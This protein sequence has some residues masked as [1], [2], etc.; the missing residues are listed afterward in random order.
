MTKHTERYARRRLAS[1]ADAS[2]RLRTHLRKLLLEKFEQ[3]ELLAADAFAP[4]ALSEVPSVA[5]GDSAEATPHAE[6]LHAPA[7]FQAALPSTHL[8]KLGDFLSG[9][10]PSSPLEI[11]DQFLMERATEL[12]LSDLDLSDY[13]VTDNYQSTH[14]GV[15]HIYLQ[16]RYNGLPIA[17]ANANINVTEDGRIINVGSSFTPLPDEV[18]NRT[19]TRGIAAE[20]S[21]S[22]AESNARKL[23]DLSWSALAPTQLDAQAALE[24]LSVEL[25]W[26]IGESVE[27]IAEELAPANRGQRQTL[28]APDVSLDEIPAELQYVAVP[29]GLE[30]SWRLVVRRPDGMNWYDAHVSAETGELLHLSDWVSE[31]SY[32]VYALPTES[33]SHGGRTLEVDPQD[34][35]ASPFGWHDTNGV[36]GAEFNTTQGN[37]VWAY[38]D[39]DGDNLPDAGS[40]PDGGAALVFNPPLNFAGEPLTYRDASVTNLFYLSN[41]LHD[42]H[43]RYGFDESAG[44]FQENNY[45]NGGV[46]GDYVLAEAQDQADGGPSGPQRNNANFATPPDGINGRMQMFLFDLTTPERDAALDAG[47]VIHEYAHGVSTRLTGGPSNSGSLGTWQ[48]AGMGEGWSDWYA[49]ML[50]QRAGD[51]ANLARGAGTY[52][53]GQPPTGLGGRNLP[54]TYDMSVNN[55]TYASIVDELS[56]HN[57][58]EVWASVLWDLNWAMIDGSS[59]NPAYTTPGLGFDA[60]FYDG[61]G[62]NNLALQLV[63]DGMKLQP[64]SPSFLD[65][66][67]AILAADQVLTGGANQLTIWAVFARRG[68][69]YSADDGGSSNSTFVTEAFDMPSTSDGEITFA[70]VELSEGSL[71][72]VTLRD[73]DLTSAQTIQISSSGGD[74]ETIVLDSVGVF[75]VYLGQI[76][77]G[78]G[79][80]AAD[81]VLQVSAGDTISI[82]YIDADDGLGGTDVPNTATSTVLTRF[83]V[84]MEQ[85]SPA[86]ALL[87]ASRNLAITRSSADVEPFTFFAEAGELIS[88]TAQPAE[89]AI[90]D[91]EIVGLTSA[92][93]SPAAGQIAVVPPTLI[94]TS[95]LYQLFLSSDIPAVSEV[96][97]TRNMVSERQLGDTSDGNE[98]KLDSSAIS[99]AGGTRYA[100]SAISVPI[101]EGIVNGSFE[102]GDFFGWDVIAIGNVLAPWTVSG[103]G[104]GSGLGMQ[105][106]Q[107]Q[108]GG[109]VA[110]N[111]FE[112]AGPLEFLMKQDVL[113]PPTPV[114]LSWQD[115]IQWD[116]AFVGDIATEGRTFEVQV[117][118]IETGIV[119]DT[120]YSF[121]TEP[122]FVAATG[123]TGWQTHTVDLSAFAGQLIE[124]AFLETVPQILTGPAQFEIDDIKLV[125]MPA[126]APDVDEFTF[127]L[128]GKAGKQID[129]LLSSDR[130]ALANA[131]LELIDR[132]GVTVLATGTATPLGAST[133]VRNFRSGILGFTAPAD[134]V[135]TLRVTSADYG[136]YTVVVNESLVFDTDSKSLVRSLDDA[137]G[138]LGS[139]DGENAYRVVET[140]F[141]F[142]ELPLFESNYVF[143]GDDAVSPAQSLGFDFEFYDQTHSSVHA[144]SNGFLTFLPNQY[145][146]CCIA[147]EIPNT[148]SPN[149]II[150]GWWRDLSPGDGSFMRH[151]TEGPVGERVFLFEVNRWAHFSDPSLRVTME[152]KL[153]EATGDIEVHYV[154]APADGQPHVAGIENHAGTDGLQLYRGF[155][156]LPDHFAVRYERANVVDRYSLNLDAGEEV[157]LRTGTPFDATGHSVPNTLDPELRIIHPDGSTIVGSDQNSLDGKN[158]Q[159]TI[160]APVSG[161]YFVEVLAT[162]GV[163]AYSIEKSMQDSVGPK[164]T[165]VIVGSSAWSESFIDLVDG[166]GVDNGNGLG[167]SL[168][169]SEQ[170][171]NLPWVNLDTIYV[172]FD[173]DVSADFDASNVQIGGVNIGSYAANL[174]FVYGVDGPNI[175]TIT[176]ASPIAN[177]RISLNLLSGLRDSSGN[178]LDGE[179]SDGSSLYSGNGSAGGD[180]VFRIDA[181]PG[182]FDNSDGVNLVDVFG[183]LG[184]RGKL[185]DLTLI[186]ADVDGSGGVNLVDVF[187]VLGR[188]G[189]FL[190]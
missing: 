52:T 6:N 122:E 185:T 64:T 182:D 127:N 157:T 56:I 98:L 133:E 109:F 1:S 149:A 84:P 164:V 85:L 69:G 136:P 74:A 112:G 132:D 89:A 9:P 166:G 107:P 152:Y 163:G 34:A 104:D 106:T 46:G 28:S 188:R 73:S 30:L 180:L 5:I 100:A 51:T 39:R 143:I 144:S 38:A 82:T 57:I 110:W 146:G 140:A 18:A 115:R 87:G 155:D 76:D 160:T 29:Y 83:A 80:N 75:G 67:D 63:M 126:P 120:L 59:L 156:S 121:S 47:I 179:W 13:V 116:F 8:F 26:G 53:L 167:L 151:I 172:Q 22:L 176:F 61:T 2:F 165:N 42:I 101:G 50:T 21:K 184:D 123:D 31:A 78:A 111:G 130:A 139:V 99:V 43:Y 94:P 154:K 68:M 14:N 113:L 79:P 169:G 158:A 20:P 70:D 147:P 131:T 37:N 33:P 11:A 161:E 4:L 16:Q 137:S 118:D 174:S 124:L 148:N 55:L 58:G 108:D 134:G 183:T 177:D 178:S 119:L 32:N 23:G 187:A 54:Y 10:S 117:R 135:Y 142:V 173:E 153:F 114:S 24:S 96:Y 93:Q 41:V 171:T 141:D 159:L 35:T 49:L 190:P 95:G 25:G 125:G 72:T 102:T 97:L 150:A 138:V 17:N 65:A 175:G 145:H 162:S 71:V 186:R 48:S 170:L 3:R 44:N 60:D 27:L 45:G 81:G 7:Q 12:A 86:G 90:I 66:R 88:V 15:T 91:L 77:T 62:G 36:A 19:T 92:S 40:S 105:P 129:L 168:V 103:A 189:T 181:L 128:Q